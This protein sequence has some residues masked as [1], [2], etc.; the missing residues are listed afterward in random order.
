MQPSVQLLEITLKGCLVGSPPQ[1][2]H[3]G[4]GIL[5]EF[6]KRRF[7]M[8]DAEVM[9][10]RGE[11]LLLPFACCFP[12]TFQRLGHAC[13]TLCSVRALL[14]RVSLGL[15]PWLHRL[16]CGSL[17]IVRRLPSYYGGVRLL[18][19]VH[20]RLRL[21]TFPTRTTCARP[22]RPPGAHPVPL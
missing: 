20:H 6:G 14:V 19:R 2:V 3:A 18:T 11:L 8:F 5:L 13:P 15:R 9:E 22:S 17:R 21:L 12:Y 7:Q 16:R 4:R 1:P 10:E